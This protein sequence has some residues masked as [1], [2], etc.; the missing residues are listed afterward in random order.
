MVTLS[1]SNCIENTNL[2]ILDKLVLE[3]YINIKEINTMEINQSSPVQIDLILTSKSQLQNSP[4]I[5]TTSFKF[6]AQNAIYNRDKHLFYV[7][8]SDKIIY[9]KLINTSKSN[10]KP[11]KWV[12]K[13]FGENTIIKNIFKYCAIEDKLIVLDKNNNILEII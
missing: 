4:A 5:S 10:L 2:K 8:F 3:D 6:T 11:I 13:E 1:E 9:T 12:E 7:V